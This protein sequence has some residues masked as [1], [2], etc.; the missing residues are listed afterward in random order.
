VENDPLLGPG[1]GT[2]IATATG[3]T[4]PTAAAPTGSLS[5]VSSLPAPNPRI[6]AASLASGA[7]PTPTLN[8]APRLQ[9]GTPTTTPRPA[10][11]WQTAGTAAVS[12]TRSVDPAT[13]QGSGGTLQPPIPVD[14]R[15]TAVPVSST[16]GQTPILTVQQGL[17]VLTQKKATTYG[18]EKINNEYKFLCQLPDPQ[19]PTLIHRYEASAADDVGAVRAVIE[20]IQRDGR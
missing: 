13:G 8:T 20:Q 2:P 6:T 4:A 12:P 5:E 14:P 7:D 19:N 10:D 18:P 15:S 17:N 11:P 3:S 9:I 1:G 16:S